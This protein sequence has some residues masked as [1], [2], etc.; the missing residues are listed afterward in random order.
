[1]ECQ[2]V[3]VLPLFNVLLTQATHKPPRTSTEHISMRENSQ[4]GRRSGLCCVCA[5]TCFPAVCCVLRVPMF[6]V[7][8]VFVVHLG[9]NHGLLLEF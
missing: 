2:R 3:I 1:M 7:L 9:I 4:E 6:R 5:G 8:Y